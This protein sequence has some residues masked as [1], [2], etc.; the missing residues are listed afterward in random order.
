MRFELKG[1]KE[2]KFVCVAG[3]NYVAVTDFLLKTQ[4]GWG[5]DF[6][7]KPGKNYYAFLVDGKMTL[8]PANPEVETVPTEDGVFRMNVKTI[9]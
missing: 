9:R 2:A 4:D 1:Y 5:G 3:L 7:L 6:A 8:D